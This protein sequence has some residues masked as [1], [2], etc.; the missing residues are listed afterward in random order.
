MKKTIWTC[1]LVAFLLVP[2]GLWAA[3]KDKVQSAIQ[4]NV[5]KITEARKRY[6]SLRKE[7]QTE[8]FWRKRR[9]L[10]GRPSERERELKAEVSKAKQEYINTQKRAV[11]KRK[12]VKKKTGGK[13]GQKAAL[14]TLLK[15]Y[16]RLKKDYHKEKH[17][18]EMRGRKI[19]TERENDLLMKMN[20]AKKSYDDTRALYE[21]KSSTKAQ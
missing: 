17:W 18:R 12:S 7:Y 9:G 16:K 4:T 13:S 10:G 6:E 11:K 20:R 1:M 2:C 14:V 19:P 21:K 15:R 3:E 8:K 5:S